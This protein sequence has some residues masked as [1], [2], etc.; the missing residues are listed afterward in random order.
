ML[1]ATPLTQAGKH[2]GWAETRET[3]T[4]RRRER[5]RRGVGILRA[6]YRLLT[7]SRRGF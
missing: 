1:R 6:S 3:L 2:V 7:L 4:V 5:K